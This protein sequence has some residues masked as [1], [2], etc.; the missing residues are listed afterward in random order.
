MKK[1]KGLRFI[2]LLCANIVF[3]IIAYLVIALEDPDWYFLFSL[4]FKFT[5]A[6]VA[7][8]YLMEIIDTV[9]KFIKQRKANKPLPEPEKKEKE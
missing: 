6:T 2:I 4:Q 7:I 9:K 5:I 3:F 8:Y 1:K